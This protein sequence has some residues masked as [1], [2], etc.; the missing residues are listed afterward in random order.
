MPLEYA[1]GVAAR[2]NAHDMC[3]IRKKQTGV[4]KDP[5]EDAVRIERVYNGRVG[6]PRRLL[7]QEVK[8]KEIDGPGFEKPG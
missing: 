1:R 3:R 6:K 4:S 7:A 2:A 8:S 5:G